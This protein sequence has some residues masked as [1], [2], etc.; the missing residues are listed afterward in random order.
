MTG[1]ENPP[2]CG[3]SGSHDVEAPHDIDIIVERMLAMGREIR[4]HMTGPANSDLSEF[5]DEDGLPIGRG[6]FSLTDIEPALKV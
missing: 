1:T 4:A 3:S 5:Y 2:E 6:D